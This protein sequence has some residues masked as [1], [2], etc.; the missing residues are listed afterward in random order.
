MGR[1]GWMMNAMQAGLMAGVVLSAMPASGQV[2]RQGSGERREALNQMERQPIPAAVWESL[3]AWVGDKP[4]TSADRNGKAVLVVTW[5]GWFPNSH[6][7]LQTAQTLHERYADDGLVVIG[8]H[9]PRGFGARSESILQSNGVKFPVAHDAGGK[10]YEHFRVQQDPEYFLFD[11]SGQLRYAHIASASLNEA[12]QE[13]LSESYDDASTLNERLARSQA[14]RERELRRIRAINAEVDLRAIP[15]LPFMQPDEEAY[16]DARW[17]E[18]PRQRDQSWSNERRIPYAVEFPEEG[19]LPSKPK[20]TAGRVMVIYL[21]HAEIYATYTDYIAHM[22]AMQ[23]RYGRDV[24]VIGHMPP[25]LGSEGDTARWNETDEER[26]ERIR[27][28]QRRIDGV[29]R[30]FRISHPLLV[31]LSGEFLAKLS[32]QEQH[33]QQGVNIFTTFIISSDG[34]L[35]WRGLYWDGFE[36]LLDRTLANDPGVQA[37][38]KAEAEYIRAQRN[39]R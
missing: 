33:G 2:M 13:L 37:R 21:W 36:A 25:A 29:V 3:G 8:V 27:R 16:K 35:R 6:R 14:E 5:A 38:R 28:L 30:N 18:M 1:N 20:N 12:T 32:G 34:Q 23:R 24:I 31:D 19:W 15:E 9:N 4:V 7:G 10:F 26:E 39:E 22:D 17:P 11:R